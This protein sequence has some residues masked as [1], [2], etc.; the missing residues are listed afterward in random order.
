MRVHVHIYRHTHTHTHV[1][2]GSIYIYISIY[3]LIIFLNTMFL[4]VLYHYHL[5]QISTIRILNHNV[6]FVIICI[7]SI[8][9]TRI[10]IYI[11]T[12]LSQA[13]I[14]SLFRTSL[15]LLYIYLTVRREMWYRQEI[16]TSNMSSKIKWPTST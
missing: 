4:F 14:V 16:S 10:H 11:Y 8:F 12:R 9:I 15:W 7:Y 1:Q 5:K 2:Y 13:A 3:F 6:L